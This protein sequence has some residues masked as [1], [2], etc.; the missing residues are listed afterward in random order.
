MFQLHKA[1][2][3]NTSSLGLEWL[4]IGSHS[5][6]SW[7]QVSC[8]YQ[9]NGISGVNTRKCIN[10]ISN[11]TSMLGQTSSISVWY[12]SGIRVHWLNNHWLNNHWLLLPSFFSLTWGTQFWTAWYAGMQGR[13][14]IQI[15][16]VSYKHKLKHGINI[17]L[18]TDPQKANNLLIADGS[19]A[20]DRDWF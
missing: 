3:L 11:N 6:L 10:H 5:M 14:G 7:A 4:Y 19:L 18:I 12:D 9:L 2:P 13:M 16:H 17:Y 15:I 20:P 1:P 8:Q